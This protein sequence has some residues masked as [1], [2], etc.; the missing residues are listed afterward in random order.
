MQQVAIKDVTESEEKQVCALE[1]ENHIFAHI[2]LNVK[3]SNRKDNLSQENTNSSCEILYG[4][5]AM[6]KIE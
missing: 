1:K 4:K 3:N 2:Q 5:I 6:I